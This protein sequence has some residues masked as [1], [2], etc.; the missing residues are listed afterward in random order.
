M[1]DASG[2]EPDSGLALP[3]E[4]PV[5]AGADDLTLMRRH[6]AGDDEAFG[7][8][9]RRHRDRLWAVALRLLGDPEE[10]SDAVQ[11]ALVSALRAGRSGQFRGQSAVTTWLHRIVVNACLDRVRRAAVRRTDPLPEDGAR[12][13]DPTDDMARAVDRLD[14]REALAGLAVEQRAAVV[15]VD[16]QGLPVAEAAQVL[17]CPVGTVKSRCARARA[18]LLDLLE[19]DRNRPIP[20]GVPEQPAAPAPER[21][22][23]GVTG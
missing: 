13:A 19:G 2:A 9:V 3:P 1:A 7:E 14:L 18:R 8:I 16:M 23:G 20:M 11:D 12:L 17:G 5:G 21:A 6:A 10:A 4:H 22:D 15:L